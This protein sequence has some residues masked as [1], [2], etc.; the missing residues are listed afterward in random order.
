VDKFGWLGNTKS[1]E[2]SG[3]DAMRREDSHK[4]DGRLH[5]TSDMAC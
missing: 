3:D 2:L 4:I 1:E 5:M